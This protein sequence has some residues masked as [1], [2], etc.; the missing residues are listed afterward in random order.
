MKRFIFV[1]YFFLFVFALAKSQDGYIVDA[2]I[3]PDKEIIAFII[4]SGMSN[5]IFLYYIPLDTLVRKTYTTN[6][7]LDSQYKRSLNW[8]NDEQLLYISKQNGIAQQCILNVVDNSYG[9]N[10]ESFSPEYYLAYSPEY[11]E[12]FYSSSVGKDNPAIFRRELYSDIHSKISKGKHIYSYVK[13][14]PD[15]KY[16][17]FAKMPEGKL[18][19]YSLSEDKYIPLKL[20]SGGLAETLET[21]A[22]DCS[23]FIY[24]YV[25]KNVNNEAFQCLEEYNLETKKRKKIMNSIKLP[26]SEFIY[27]L[28]NAL[29][30]PCESKYIYSIEEVFYV[31][32]A[33]TYALEKYELPG[34]PVEWLEDCKSVLFIDKEHAYIFYLDSG[35]VKQIVNVQN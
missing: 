14:S 12:S 29:W 4:S 35:E 9:R 2:T 34:R 30:A 23:K 15:S 1:I 31:V 13:L 33:D 18:N 28:T 20:Y 27:S 25:K 32:D 6:L 26:E 19:L 7:P 3:S 17:S 10:G 22:P 5:E 11:K 24:S 16:L 21:W 8:M